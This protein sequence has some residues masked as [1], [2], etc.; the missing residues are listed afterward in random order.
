M[1]RYASRLPARARTDA[2][3]RVPV[4]AEAAGDS[5]LLLVIADPEAYLLPDPAMRLVSGLAAR[6]DFDVLLPVSNE[7]ETEEARAAPPFVYPTPTLLAEAAA[8]VAASAGPLRRSSA[9]DSPVFDSPAI[10]SETVCPCASFICDAI[11]RIQ[12]SS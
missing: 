8:F 1:R 2:F 5:P 10:R 11:V 3:D 4:V 9:P 6:S 12:I 7:P